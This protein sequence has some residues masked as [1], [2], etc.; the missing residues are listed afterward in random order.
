MDSARPFLSSTINTRKSVSFDSCSPAPI[1]NSASLPRLTS[2]F[3]QAGIDHIG[4]WTADLG[5]TVIALAVADLL[6][7][8]GVTVAP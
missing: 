8:A 6:R 4:V 2:Q 3:L 7:A 5:A 1:F